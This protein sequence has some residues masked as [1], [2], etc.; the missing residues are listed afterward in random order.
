MHLITLAQRQDVMAFF[1]SE[2][3][4]LLCQTNNRGDNTLKVKQASPN[5]S[6]WVTTQI[7]QDERLHK[8]V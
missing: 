8:F 6:I 1:I 3:M 2:S 7:H 4:N 5:E